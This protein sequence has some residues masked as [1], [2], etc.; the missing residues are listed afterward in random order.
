[1]DLDAREYR[2][3]RWWA[4][5]WGW[6]SF[7]PIEPDFMQPPFH[8]LSEIPHRL[9]RLSNGSAYEMPPSLSESWERLDRDLSLITHLLKTITM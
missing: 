8:P 2:N 9:H 4:R 1:M 3:P 6:I 7:F 5:P